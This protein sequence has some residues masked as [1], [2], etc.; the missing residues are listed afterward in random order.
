MDIFKFHTHQ[1]RSCS[2]TK[3]CRVLGGS[4]TVV[5]HTLLFS[6][7]LTAA[8]SVGGSSSCEYHKVLNKTTISCFGIDS[9]TGITLVLALRPIDEVAWESPHQL[10]T[11]KITQRCNIRL[12]HL[13]ISDLYNTITQR[14]SKSLEGFCIEGCA[15]CARSLKALALLGKLFF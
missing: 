10:T 11:T 9:K 4:V 15:R 8:S 2:V 3:E 1:L 6:D 5:P 14:F 7:G 12:M 13:T